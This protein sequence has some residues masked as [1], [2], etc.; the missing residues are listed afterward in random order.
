MSPSFAQNLIQTSGEDGIEG[1]NV[2]GLNLT[3]SLITNNGDDS[4]DVGVGID[5]LF[6]NSDWN[7]VSVTASEL[8]NV[9]ITNSSGTL[10]SFSVTGASHFD[11]L[12]T[13]FGGNSMLVEMNGTATMNTGLIDGAT[14]VNNKP[15]RGH[16]GPGAGQ[17]LD[18]QRRRRTPSWSR[19]RPSPTTGCMRASSSPAPP[20]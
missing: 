6:G 4:E 19:T 17:Q 9:M 11:N 7:A 8:A 15:A 2:T 14:F 10:N 1:T 5:N 12:G 13:A 20:T 3:G 18:R 16:H